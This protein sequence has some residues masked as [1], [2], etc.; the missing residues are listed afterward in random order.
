LSFFDEPR[1]GR[2]ERRFDPQFLNRLMHYNDVVAE[3]LA[4][5]FIL[6]GRVRLAPN[7]SKD[8]RIRILRRFA[9]AA[10]LSIQ[11]LADERKE[12]ARQKK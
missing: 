1:R 10:G 4:Q 8:P 5:D 6:H 12:P 7:G 3:E 2:P 9:R 11:E